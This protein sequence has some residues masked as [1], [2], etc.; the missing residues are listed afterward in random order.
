MNIGVFRTYKGNIEKGVLGSLT[1]RNP[2]DRQEGGS[3]DLRVEGVRID[4]Q[5]D[6]PRAADSRRKEARPLQRHRRRR[7]GGDLAAMRR[8][9]AVLRRRPGRHVPP[10][11]RRLLRA[12]LRQGLFRHLAANGAGDRPGGDVQHV[13]QRAGGHVGHVGSAARRLLQRLH[14]PPGHRPNLRRRTVR[15]DHPHPHASRTSPPRWSP[16][17]GP[18]WPRCSTRRPS[19]PADDVGDP[20]RLRPLQLRR[21]RGLRL[22]RLRRHGADVHLPDVA[23]VL[24]VF[25]AGYLCLKNAGGGKMRDRKMPLAASQDRGVR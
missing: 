17:C 15:V 13:P 19:L 14:V 10:R 8:A 4:V 22:Q 7:P 1:V 6:P 16:A 24:P 9:A 18:P 3:A 20:A 12:E 21:L 5:Y 2:A 23:F 25:V 11:P